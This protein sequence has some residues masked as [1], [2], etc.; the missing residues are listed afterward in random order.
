[1]T[2]SIAAGSSASFG[3]DAWA[4]LTLVVSSKATIALTSLAPNLLSSSVV[5]QAQ[6][7]TYG[8]FGVPTTVV[9][10]AVDRGV[11]YDVAG[12]LIVNGALVDADGNTFPMLTPHPRYWFHGF[13]PDQS[14]ED[15]KFRDIVT[16]NHGSFGADLPIASAWTNKLKGY[17]STVNPTGGATES[18]I[19]MPG[20]N[21]DYNGGDSL[22]IMWAGQSTPEGATTNPMGSSSN[23][24]EGGFA[25]RIGTTG[26]LSFALYG[27]TDSKFSSTTTD[28]VAGKPFVTGEYHQFAIWLNGQAKTQSMWVDGQINVSEASFSSGDAI[29]T[30]SSNTWQIGCAAPTG[31]LN[32]QIVLTQAFAGLKFIGTDVLPTLSKLTAV[33]Q[34]FNR[35]PRALVLA[36]SL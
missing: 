20:P 33:V 30:L 5:S 25:V 6:S 14:T 17:I 29:N 2:T 21:F 28:T 31:G 27:G 19:T 16:G 1:M 32:G 3:M 15:L 35:D 11:T 7:K 18:Y 34:A 22:L 36:A 12:N 24:S 13:A 4:T 10:T 26:R 9:V 8:P 23:S